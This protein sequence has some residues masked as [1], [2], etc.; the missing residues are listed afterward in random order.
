[1]TI[2]PAPGWDGEDARAR[3]SGGMDR[4]VV[5]LGRRAMLALT[6]VACA[7]GKTREPP[8]T[9][10]RGVEPASCVLPESLPSPSPEPPPPPTTET[11]A[12]ATSTVSPRTATESCIRESK[13]SLC[14]P[15]FGATMEDEASTTRGAACTSA[16]IGAREKRLGPAIDR[17]LKVCR[18]AY[19]KGRARSKCDFPKVSRPADAR[20]VSMRFQDAL[21][22]AVEKRDESSAAALDA[23]LP[24]LDAPYLAEI[25]PACTKRCRE[26]AGP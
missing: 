17:A 5:G 9:A 4:S 22:A 14:L 3:M 26:D 16:C 21:R 23:M 18:D 24:V 11:A 13:V 8:P 15:V 20:E 10:S 1:M 7:C 25:E 2:D 6:V 19:A 12:P